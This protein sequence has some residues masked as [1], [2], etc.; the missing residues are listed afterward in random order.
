VS[1]ARFPKVCCAKCRKL[2]HRDEAVTVV[3]NSVYMRICLNCLE[4]ERIREP[5]EIEL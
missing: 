5:L 4:D 3:E 2:V 1:G